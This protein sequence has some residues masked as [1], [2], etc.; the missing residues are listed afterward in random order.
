MVVKSDGTVWFTDPPYGIL[1]DYEGYKADS[2][3]GANY[4][5]RLD[6]ESRRLSVVADDFDKP[7]G[8][9]FS[10][11]ESILYIADTGLS[12]NVDG[13]HHIRAF[14]V[15]GGDT[16]TGGEVFADVNPGVADGFR[17]DTGGNVWTSAGDGIHCYAPDGTLLGKILIPEKVSNCVFGG[18][19]RNRLFVTATTSLYAV[20]LNARG[21][22][23]P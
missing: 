21:V 16:L 1:T 20:Y 6:P 2:E 10:P 7:N 5:Y 15:K 19:R 23:T 22:Q 9:A 13:P 12:H 3:I 18:A 4:V 8:L 14:S 11:D 17:L